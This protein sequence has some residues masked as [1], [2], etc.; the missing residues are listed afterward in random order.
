[1]TR[2]VI[3]NESNAN[4]RYFLVGRASLLHQDEK[5]V[6]DD[7][8]GRQALLVDIA[9]E[10]IPG[11]TVLLQAISP[12]IFAEDAA[13]LL[14]VIDQERERDHQRIG[15]VIG[16]ECRIARLHERAIKARGDPRMAP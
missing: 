12:E 5:V 4:Q 14:D 10:R 15:V 3:I 11:G 16:L 6:G 8:L 13:R 7:A 9:A 1:F 2:T